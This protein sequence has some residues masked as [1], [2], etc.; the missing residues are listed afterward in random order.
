MV[1]NCI[2][3]EL[4][5]GNISQ[6]KTHADPGA[7]TERFFFFFFFTALYMRLAAQIWAAALWLRIPVLR[8]L[9]TPS[10]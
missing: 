3:T 2:V 9:N 5:V 6:S 1:E 8:F 10:L 7:K 4:L